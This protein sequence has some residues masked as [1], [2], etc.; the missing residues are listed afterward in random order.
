MNQES[1]VGCGFLKT[2]ICLEQKYWNRSNRRHICGLNRIRS[3]GI[4]ILYNLKSIDLSHSVNLLSTPDFRVMPFLETLS[5]LPSHVWVDVS[6]CISLDTLSNPITQCNSALSAYCFNCFKMM[7]NESVK[8]IALSLL[9]RYLQEPEICR[10]N[11]TTW[12]L[13]NHGCSHCRHKIFNFVAPGN[14]IP[15]WYNHQSEGS[16][17]IVELHPG[18]FSNK[19]MGFSLCAVFR[20]RKPLTPFASI[21]IVCKLTHD[22]ISYSN[23][24]CVDLE[25][26][27]QPVV[28]HTGCSMCTVIDMI[29]WEI[30]GRIST[31]SLNF[32]L[33]TGFTGP[34]HDGVE[35][36]KCGFRMI[37]EED[38]EQLRQTLWKQSNVG[39]NTKRGLQH[40]N[41]DNASVNQEKEGEP[42]PKRF[43]QLDLALDLDGA[44]PSGSACIDD[45]N[46]MVST[47]CVPQS[48]V[49]TT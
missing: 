33:L 7:E 34:N 41:D 31:I 27:G 35:V 28:D 14:E 18:W 25:E 32:H 2:L 6:N 44:G 9:I 30:T 17:I 42:H 16:L 5:E 3:R 48:T 26:S 20:L 40:Y 11:F 46:M 15:E 45:Q 12:W 19:W 22:G 10:D 47:V 43:K 29:T 49:S 37:Y 21:K 36:K 1:A 8:S 24:P 4:E 13:R 39:I 23:R 38:V